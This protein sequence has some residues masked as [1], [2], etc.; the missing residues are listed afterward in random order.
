MEITKPTLILDKTVCLNNIRRMAK[1]AQ[2]YNIKFRPHFKTHQS[3]KI[4]NWFREFG[5]TSITVRKCQ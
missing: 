2:K 4:G 1:K 5:V 3:A